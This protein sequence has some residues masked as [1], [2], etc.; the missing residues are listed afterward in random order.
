MDTRKL[1]NWLIGFGVI[2]FIYLVRYT[3]L[4][5]FSIKSMDIVRQKIMLLIGYVV[6]L[7]G[8]IFLLRHD[9]ERER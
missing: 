1:R 7:P 5:G 2:V 9:E 3:D 6:V 8:I 4:F